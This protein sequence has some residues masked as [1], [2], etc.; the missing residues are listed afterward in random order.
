MIA[1]PTAPTISCPPG[2]SMSLAVVESVPPARPV[3]GGDLDRAPAERA[4]D[5]RLAERRRRACASASCRRSRRGS[6]SAN[7]SSRHTTRSS[8]PTAIIQTRSRPSAARRGAAGRRCWTRC[9]AFS[10]KRQLERQPARRA[11][12]RRR[13]P[14]ARPGSRGRA[15]RCRGPADCAVCLVGDLSWRQPSRDRERR[16]HPGEATRRAAQ[17]RVARSRMM[18]AEQAVDEGRRLV[19]REVLDE[20]H[21]LA[22][23]DAR[24]GRRRRTAA[25]RRRCAARC[26]RPPA[27]GSS[28]QPSA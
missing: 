19:G 9:S 20:V 18:R 26:G 5:D 15:S 2:R 16:G 24:P 6:R 10:P 27:S 17:T 25:R 11:G 23:R 8:M 12:G 4:V 22:D 21:R 28:V 1:S 13:R 7:S 14:P 3:T